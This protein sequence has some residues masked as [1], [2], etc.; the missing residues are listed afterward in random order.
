MGTAHPSLAQVVTYCRNTVV[1]AKLRGLHVAVLYTI[2]SHYNQ[3]EGCARPSMNTICDELPGTHIRSIKYAI[4]DLR[5]H[6]V[7]ATWQPD[8]RSSLRYRFPLAS[9]VAT[10]AGYPDEAT[11]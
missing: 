5:E 7:F 6:G 10:A 3:R 11:G 8:A 1:S 9:P 4:A 2:A